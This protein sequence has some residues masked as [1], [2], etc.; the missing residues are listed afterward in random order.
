[1]PLYSDPRKS[2]S[3]EVG[4]LC[5]GT[6]GQRGASRFFRFLATVTPRQ[7]FR[8]GSKNELSTKSAAATQMQLSATLNAGQ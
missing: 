5:W 6:Q 2:R 7:G 4:Q 8:A 1:M 3:A